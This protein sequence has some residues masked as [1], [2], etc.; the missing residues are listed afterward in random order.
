MLLFFQLFDGDGEPDEENAAQIEL[1][2][3]RDVEARTYIYSTVKPEQQVALQGCRTAFEMWNRIL[4]EYAEATAESESSLW[5]QF[6]NYKFRSGMTWQAE[7]RI[8]FIL[9]PI[10]A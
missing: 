1:W 9:S 6:Y 5:S 10:L 3:Q 8:K 2:K 7:S 4:I